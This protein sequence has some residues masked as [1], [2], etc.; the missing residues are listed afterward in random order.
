MNPSNNLKCAMNLSKIEWVIYF[1]KSNE[2]RKEDNFGMKTKYTSLLKKKILKI[3][4]L[5]HFI[6]IKRD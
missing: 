6:L 5:L 3:V 1:K 4:V 2:M